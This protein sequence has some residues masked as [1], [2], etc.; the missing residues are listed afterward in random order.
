MVLQFACVTDTSYVIEHT[1]DLRH[2]VW[3]AVTSPTLTFPTAGTCQ[4]IDD[5][6]RTGGMTGSFRAYRVKLQAE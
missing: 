6:T 4:W 3:T 5:G 1:A 2:A